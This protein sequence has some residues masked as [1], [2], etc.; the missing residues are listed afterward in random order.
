VR[1]RVLLV[2][3]EFPPQRGGIGTHCYEMARHWAEY[4]DV[5]VLAPAAGRAG[6]T[7]DQP[8]ALVELHAPRGRLLRGA[9]TAWAIRRQLAAGRYDLAYLAHWRAGGVAYGVAA[10]GRRRRPRCM[11]AVHGGEL[12]YLLVGAG[13]ATRLERGLFRWT[14]SRASTMVALGEYQVGLLERLGVGRERTFVSSEGVRMAPFERPPAAERLASLRRRHGLQGAK[15]LLTVA[16]LVPHKGHDMVIRALPRIVERVPSAA[17]LVVGSGPNEAALR[18]LARRLGVAV[19]VR[20]AGSVP[21]DELADHY[22]LCD[23][24]VM[25]SRQE[26]GN[27]EGFGIVFAEAAAC[28][29]PAIGGRAGGIVDVIQDGRTG[30]LVDPTSPAEIAAAA[31]RLL[32]DCQLAA[33]LGAAARSRIEREFRY[34][35]VAARILAASGVAVG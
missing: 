24:F 22:H 18:D 11:L 33:R 19:H 35:D 21:D 17:Y 28:A 20:F 29:R 14:A 12:L 27:V 1:P 4:A 25:P 23:V 3:P 16:R 5:T 32:T 7:S 2:T 26:A 34:E 10:A 8:F 30:L 6:G 15:V 9:T 31:I 13:V